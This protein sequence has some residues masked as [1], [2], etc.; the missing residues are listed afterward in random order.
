MSAHDLLNESSTLIKQFEI[1]WVKVNVPVK[2]GRFTVGV[3][4][5]SAFK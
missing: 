4:V 5:L 3:Y 1:I 2:L